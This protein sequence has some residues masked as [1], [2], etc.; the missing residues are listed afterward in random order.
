MTQLQGREASEAAA[1]ER[2][3]WLAGQVRGY[4]SQRILR[5]VGEINRVLGPG[6]VRNLG[7]QHKFPT[8]P[9]A[10]LPTELRGSPALAFVKTLVAVLSLDTG[11]EGPVALLRKNALKLLRVPEYAPMAEFREPCVTF[12][13]RDAVCDYCSACVDLDLC[14]DERLVEEQNWDCVSCGNPYDPQW[15]E[16]TLVAHVNE[17]VRT[18]QLQDLRCGRDRRIKVSHLGARCACGGLYKCVEDQ[19]AVA[20][21]LRVMHDIA[22]HHEFA[23]LKDVVEWVVRSSPNLSHARAVLELEDAK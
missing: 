17:R 20:D 7:P 23:V 12:V 6:T 10:H 19:S 18:A 21:D 14:R 1:E 9:G 5:L 8:P 16:G 4:F 15:I 11:V 13:M 2:S 3:A 22:R